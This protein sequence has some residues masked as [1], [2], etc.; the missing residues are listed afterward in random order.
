MTTNVYITDE[1]QQEFWARVAKGPDCWI[2]KGQH[3]STGKGLF[4][5]SGKRRGAHRVSW[6]IDHEQSLPSWYKVT[7]TCG[8]DNCVRPS[9]L[10]ILR[11]LKPKGVNG[12]P[13]VGLNILRLGNSTVASKP[14]PRFSYAHLHTYLVDLKQLISRVDTLSGQFAQL[15]N[16][17]SQL[18]NNV[19]QIRPPTLSDITEAIELIFG[20]RLSTLER[21]MDALSTRMEELIDTIEAAPPPE[22]VP[23]PSS[24]REP[25]TPPAAAPSPHPEPKAPPVQPENEL[26]RILMRA[27]QAEMGGP[28]DPEDADH[29]ALATAFELAVADAGDSKGAVMVYAGWLSAFRRLTA[30][31][32]GI[33][34][35]PA[36]F[37][38]QLA[39]GSL[40]PALAPRLLS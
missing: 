29:E 31:N 27:F 14:R 23:P 39:S 4:C 35:T 15:Q 11:G 33:E 17:N 10:K 28:K 19:G 36:A 25:E 26:R 12:K 8:V 13:K 7:T 34:R 9:H 3:S 18:L 16:G 24:P 6:V 2:W 38:A 22:V 21:R 37:A 5:I 40:G 30:E 1:Y 20:G 32:E